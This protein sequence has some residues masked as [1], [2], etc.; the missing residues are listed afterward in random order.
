[1]KVFRP[2]AVFLFYLALSMA[3]TAPISLRPSELA[4]NDGDPL[5]ISW[6]LAWDAHQ[7]VRNPLHLFDSNSFY[8][9][10]AS[11]AFSEHLLGPALLAAPFFYATGN[12]LFAQN[13]AVLLTLSL[14]AFFMFLLIREVF[15]TE[16]G[17][18]VAG[19]VYAFHA[20]NLH[21]VARLQLLSVQWWPLAALFL[22]RTFLAGLP[23]A[24]GGSGNALLAALFFTLQGLSCTYY[25]L[26][27]ALLLLL[28]IP[29]YAL[30]TDHGMRRVATLIAPFAAAGALFVLIG[31]PYLR[32]VRD[33]GFGRELAQGA[34]LAE[35]FRPPEGSLYGSFVTFDHPPG[36]VP[37][38]LGFVA[39]A[40]A[41]WGLVRRPR[42]GD[43]RTRVVFF[44]LSMATAFVGGA[45]SLGPTLRAFGLE[46]GPGPYAW[47]YEG[48]PIFRVLRNAER[49][50]VLVHFGLAVAAGVGAGAL[51]A[52]SNARWL[53]ILLLVA[54]P[55]EHFAGG[56]PFT[57]VPTGE[58]APDVYRWL[59]KRGGVGAVVELPL[60]PREKLRL[61]SLY[62]FYSTYHWKPI[63]FG[64][65]S[66]YPPLTGYLGWEMRN[67]PDADSL[68]LLE[69]LGVELLVV[70]PNLWRP[71][72]REARLARLQSFADRLELEG[73]FGPTRDVSQ[74]RY[75]LGDER[76]Y[77]LRHSGEI[78]STSELCAPT[79]EIAPE[80]FRLRGDSKSPVEWVV[81]RNPETKWRTDGQLP[82][83]KLEIDLG[84]EETLAAVGL[85]LGYPHDQFPRDLTLKVR[86]EG[87]NG[88][89]RVEPRHDRATKWELVRALVEGPSSASV[90]LR[91]PQTKARHLRFWIR[92]G[93]EWD[94]SLPD[95]SL[96]ELHLYR[97]C[98]ASH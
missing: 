3:F 96:P 39:L 16:L 29:G 23:G 20:Y 78:P 1:M 4:V 80:G 59:D 27:F 68:A 86:T 97:A 43:P 2:L 18:L 35:Y 24:R 76:V 19:V 98:A 41:L 73:R 12:A 44:W 92:E 61:H 5:H 83:L 93:K 75:G 66:F 67:F 34:D 89:E 26:Y 57:R 58:L 17:A 40:L 21:E 79:D 49:L 55:F 60:Y 91:F 30:T 46:L 56:Q 53:R 62:M 74:A 28:W 11:L 87:G 42:T 15:A 64:R 6:I 33:F 14:S 47:L 82:G 48:L 37:Q 51:P 63:V 71:G 95:W 36:V 88:F 81:D 13:V 85:D 7:I 25:L 9:Y 38:F 54:L 65:T 94:Y 69:G 70:H 32:M 90:T 31:F 52:L 84:R 72:E 22:H 45:L 8:P 77:R 10:P 50:S